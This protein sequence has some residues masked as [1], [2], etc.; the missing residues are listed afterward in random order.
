MDFRQKV[1]SMTAKEIIMAMVNGLKARHVAIN[2]TTFGDV[3]DG[4]CYGCAATNTICEISGV[5]FNE[6]NIFEPYHAEGV[7]LKDGDSHLLVLFISRFEHA[8]NFL[9]MGQIKSY[10]IIARQNGIAEIKIPFQS[11]PFLGKYF[12]EKELN[13][14][15]ELAN[16]QS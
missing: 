3:I 15:I 13:C 5:V 9:R 12:T 2:M 8:I 1:Q 16:L 4:V 14:Y 11:P 7:G 6:S 10:N